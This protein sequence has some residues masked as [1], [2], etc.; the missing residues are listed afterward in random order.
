MNY[1]NRDLPDKNKLDVCIDNISNEVD[2]IFNSKIKNNNDYIRL[3]SS[4]LGK[5]EFLA[6]SKAILEGNITLGYYNTEYEKLAKEIF[7]SNNCLTSNSGSSA[8]LLAI[9]S[10]VNSGKL[11][12]G[13]KVIVPALAWS[14]TIF[15]LVQYGLVPVYVDCCSETF[16]INSNEIIKCCQEHTIKGIMVIHTYGNPAD[17]DFLV[18]FC[19]SKSIILIED[20]CESMGAKW[21]DKP[22][23]SFGDLGTFSSYYSHHICTLEGGLTISKDKNLDDLMRSIRSHGWTRGIDFD[24]SDET[25]NGVDPN[26]L[27]LNI[28]YNLRLSDPQAAVGCVQLTKLHTFVKKRTLVAERYKENIS[29]LPNLEENL[30]FPKVLDEGV[31]SWFGF[32]VLLPYSSKEEIKKLRKKLLDCKIETRP[33][34]AGDFSLQPVNKKF[35]HVRF[36]SL[37]NVELCHKNAFALPCHQDISMQD[38]DKVCSVINEFLIKY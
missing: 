29:K 2:L 21:K 1:F 28:G 32:P 22:V 16:N 9:S 6:F 33:F 26:F 30:K 34:L 23:G 35:A 13:D 24:L 5:E 36:N 25:T 19:E 27:F 4:T 14:T 20:T 11:N 38:V 18:N 7:K 10:L 3:H 31:S 37:K 12:R 17:M 15:P 8:N